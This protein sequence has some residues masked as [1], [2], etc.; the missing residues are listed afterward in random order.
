MP[1]IIAYLFKLFVETADERGQ[2]VSLNNIAIIHKK[3]QEYPLAIESAKKSLELAKQI[4][5]KEDIKNEL[6]VVIKYRFQGYMIYQLKDG[7]V[8]NTELNNLDKAVLVAQCDIKDNIAQMINLEF[9]P[10]VAANI[11]K[12]K[13]NGSNEGVVAG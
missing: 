11:P 1:V 7:S 10:T 2:I 5:D 8:S 9:D 6:N 3:K 13:V 12:E 4:D